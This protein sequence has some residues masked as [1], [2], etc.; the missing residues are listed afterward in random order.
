MTPSTLLLPARCAASASQFGLFAFLLAPPTGCLG[1]SNDDD[2]G[3]NG[4]K[5]NGAERVNAALQLDAGIGEL[6]Q[7]LEVSWREHVGESFELA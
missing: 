6:K 7:S 5:G 1:S 4:G 3:G 2:N